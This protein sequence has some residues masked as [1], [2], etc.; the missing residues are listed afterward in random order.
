[1]TQLNI[2]A[3]ILLAYLS[4]YIIG[5]L[6]LGDDEAR[7]MFGV[8]AGPAV[9]FFLMLFFTPQS[10][11]WLISKGRTAEARR[12]FEACGTDAGSVEE[13]IA[14][15]QRSFDLAH[16][17]LSENFFQK[18]YAKPITMAIAIA[19]F[20]QLSGIN[21]VLYY[22]GRIFKMAGADKA[23]ALLQSVTIGLTL[24]VFT[25]VALV[26]IDHFGRRKLMLIGSVGYILSLGATSY[27]FYA[28]SGGWW[29]LASLLAFV[30]SHAVGQGAIIWVF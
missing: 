2:V 19:A 1:I 18:K 16:H 22:A 15:V 14:A 20:N 12:V 24:L 4:N 25:L 3:G 21:A 5:R 9:V 28:N 30:A 11:R 17:D 23:S 29:L 10:P 27:C 13:E 7:W 6:N 8:M 26:A